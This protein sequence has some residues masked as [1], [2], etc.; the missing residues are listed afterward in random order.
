VLCDVDAD[1]IKALR[2]YMPTDQLLAQIGEVT[3]PELACST[4]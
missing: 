3:E 4:G 2:S 1:K